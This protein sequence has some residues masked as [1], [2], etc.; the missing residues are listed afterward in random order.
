MVALSKEIKIQVPHQ[1]VLGPM[2][3]EMV[4]VS[5]KD[6]ARMEKQILQ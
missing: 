1:N 6:S 3:L 2:V 4:S 5:M